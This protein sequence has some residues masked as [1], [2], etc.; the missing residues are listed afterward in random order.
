MKRSAGSVFYGWVVVACAFALMFTG[1]GATYS[2]AAFFSAFQSEFGGSRAHVSA[3]FSIGAFVYFLLGA[4]GGMLADRHG[5]RAVC[6]T[7]ILFLATG[8]AAASL[9]DSLWM[10]YA[11]Y[12]LAIGVG[13]G[14][15]YVP[16]VGAVQPWFIKQR[17]FASGLAVSGIGAGN[18]LVPL[19]ALWWIGLF[20]WRGAYLALAALVLVIG[21][22]AGWLI[23]N[24]PRRHGVG[25]DGTAVAA[26]GAA[27]ANGTVRARPPGATLREAFGSTRFWWMYASLSVSGIAC[28]VPM[29]H[30]TPYARDAGMSEAAAVSLVSLIG[31]GSLAGRFAIGWFA[32]RMGRM[33]SA[34]AMYA[35]MGVFLIAWWASTGGWALALVAVGYGVCYGGFVAVQ[36]PIVMDLFGARNVSGIIGSLYTGVGFGTL[37]GPT[38]AGAAFDR[39]GSYDVPILASALACFAATAC[40]LALKRSLRTLRTTG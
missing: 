2:F 20:G 26:A 6:L 28:F 23:D 18:F 8:V 13:V 38:L 10:L 30:M 32:D 22:V 4:S 16:S 15:T 1:F 9:A 34:A 33:A 17:A 39:S 5:P 19:I 40:V 25:A 36:P 37:L 11:T 27:A 24:D 14:L 7:G 3:V 35:G 21:G 31:L 12:S 29:V